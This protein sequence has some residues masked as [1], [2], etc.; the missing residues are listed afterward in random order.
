[1][2]PTVI[3]WAI[4]ERVAARLNTELGTT[5]TGRPESVVDWMFSV[6]RA[7]QWRAIAARASQ[8]THNP[9]LARRLDLLGNTEHP[10]LLPDPRHRRDRPG[11]TT[12]AGG[13]ASTP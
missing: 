12:L 10:R 11:M 13:A 2:V 6:D 4:P 3:G 1:M 8:A 7:V 5:F 9:V